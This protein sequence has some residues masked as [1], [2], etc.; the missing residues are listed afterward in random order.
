MATKPV[1][2]HG[3]G[4]HVLLDGYRKLEMSDG[5]GQYLQPCGA[6]RFTT[7]LTQHL[8]KIVHCLRDVHR[9]R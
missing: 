7:K 2:V 6:T 3:I 9:R 4:I 1:W 5:G 8:V